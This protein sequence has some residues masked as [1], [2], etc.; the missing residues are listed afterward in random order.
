[1]RRRGAYVFGDADLSRDLGTT[2]VDLS[3]PNGVACHDS[4]SAASPGLSAYNGSARRFT[5]E[6][7]GEDSFPTS[8]DL[9]RAGCPGPRDA[10]ALG[11]QPVAS[12]SVPLRML[13]RRAFTVGLHDAWDF[14]S[15]GY[16]GRN[17]SRFRLDL[18]RISMH[19]SYR[20]ARGIG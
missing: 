12:G 14:S 3:R 13:G 10:D 16:S 18:R 20:R 17:T 8:V 4:A 7:G 9:I 6:L 1:V 2:T 5:F 15:N 19:A 11:F